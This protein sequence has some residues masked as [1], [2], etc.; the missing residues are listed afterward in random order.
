M[1]HL[2]PVESWLFEYLLNALWQVPLIFAATWI[3]ARIAHRTGPHIEHRLWVAALFLEVLLPAC[4][5]RVTELLQSLWTTLRMSLAG[6]ADGS[7][8]RILT[9][10]AHTNSSGLLHLSPRTLIAISAIYGGTLLYFIG[11]LAWGLWKTHLLQRSAQPVTLSGPAEQTWVRLQTSLGSNP[12]HL[13]TAS[14]IAGPITIGIS[15]RLLLLPHGFLETVSTADLDAVLAHE[16]AHMRRHD[17][18][19]NLLY[20]AASLPVACHPMLWLTRARIAESREIICDAL[21]TESI[22]GRENYARSL[23]RLA[24]T[25]TTRRQPATLHAIGIFDAN[26]FERRIMKLTRNSKDIQGVRRYAIVAACALAAGV[27]CASAMA[28]RVSVAQPIAAGADPTK[29]HVKA[30]DLTNVNK[31]Q[32][33]YPVDAKK[34]G[35]QGSVVLNVVISKEGVPENIQVVSGRRELQQSALDAVRQWR[36]QPYLLN[37]EPVEVETSITVIYS[38][39]G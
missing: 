1:I 28:L 33:V 24:S 18:A 34:A 7:N 27:L 13:A 22:A 6:T 23:L 21:A 29:I 25:L 11:R 20:A 12:A 3:M 35:V 16:C 9:G 38:L 39:A 5:L 2:L 10:P 4:R 26:L 37:G 8:V 32:P 19:K 36:Y 30:D 17:F 15:R 31:V 14:E